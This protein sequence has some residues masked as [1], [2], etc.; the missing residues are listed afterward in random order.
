M[1]G[2]VNDSQQLP[3]GQ[4]KVGKA[5]FNGNAP[6]LFL[7]ETVRVNAREC[8]DQGCFSVVDMAC[9]SQND[10]FHLMNTC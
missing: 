1:S 9:G 8:P 6:F 5:Q 2:H 4:L 3:A 10:L 7:L